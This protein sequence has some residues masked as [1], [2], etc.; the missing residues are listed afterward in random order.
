M[1]YEGQ[2]EA[3]PSAQDGA[4]AMRLPRDFFTLPARERRELVWGFTQRRSHRRPS[5]REAIAHMHEDGDPAAVGALSTAL[6]LDPDTLVKRHAAFGLSCIPDQTV[7][8]A[9]LSALTFP[10]RATKGHAIL[11]LGALH[12]REAVPALLRMLDDSY[13]RIPAADALVAIADER[14]LEPLRDAAAR[15]SW[16]RRRRLRERVSALETALGQRRPA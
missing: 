14:A 3:I 5:T 1:D 2:P 12:V 8:P 15:G 9:L 10:D 13:G 11:A 6:E 16:L 4:S 7:V